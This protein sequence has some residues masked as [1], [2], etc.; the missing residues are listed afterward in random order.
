[1]PPE[2]VPSTVGRR[3]REARERKGISLADIAN[4]TKIS[5]GVL[6]ALERNDVSKLPGGI[7][8]RAFV[9]SYANAVGLNSEQLIRDFMAEFSEDS[10]SAGHP[11]SRT[12]EDDEGFES[13]RRVASVFIKLVVISIPIVIALLYF[14][15]LAHPA[16]P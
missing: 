13:N 8:T 2:S 10:V 5:V 15:S 7:F 16:A 1:M 9:R 14:S 11:S 3:L 6:E 4:A 12:V